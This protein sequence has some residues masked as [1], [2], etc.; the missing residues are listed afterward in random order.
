MN[1]FVTSSIISHGIL[2]RLLIFLLVSYTMIRWKSFIVRV[3]PLMTIGFPIRYGARKRC[4]NSSK[5]RS[6]SRSWCLRG[7][8]GNLGVIS[9]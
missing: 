8:I 1:S 9:T 2:A 5:E 3:L 6:Y 7:G 4:S